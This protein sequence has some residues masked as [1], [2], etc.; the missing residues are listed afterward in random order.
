VEKQALLAEL[1][2][3][4][5]LAAGGSEPA[6]AA[7]EEAN[8]KVTNAKV[9]HVKAKAKVGVNVQNKAAGVTTGK[10][11]AAESL[12]LY[13]CSQAAPPPKQTFAVKLEAAKPAARAGC[14]CAT[15]VDARRRPRTQC[16]PAVVGRSR[17]SL[18]ARLILVAR[19][20]VRRGV[21]PD[22]RGAQAALRAPG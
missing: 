5:A 1:Q 9:V 7:N 4:V 18:L 22:Q 15:G 17:A 12:P 11:E 14:R 20:Q 3:L 2:E 13:A 21:L 8:A 6:K 19:G 10:A 16:W